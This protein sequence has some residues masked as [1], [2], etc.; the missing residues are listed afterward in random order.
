MGD[1]ELTG[2]KALV[3]GAATKR[4]MG[5]AIA[6]RLAEEGAD[7]AV[8]DRDPAPRSLFP[9]DE[10]WRGLDEIAEEIRQ[11]GRDA[12]TIVADV[13][14]F[15]E[16]ERAAKMVVDRFGGIDILVHCAAIRG[17]PNIDVVDGEV[18]EWRRIFEVN[19]L[20]S[21]IV[22]KCVGRYMIE[23]GGGKIVLFA[24][25]AAR[26]GVKG[27]AA[28]A[29]SKWGVIGLVQSLALEL[30]PYKINVNAVCP[31]MIITN[32]RD[33]YFE[34]QAR[35]M[36]TSPEEVRQKEYAELSKII[37]LGRMGT[38]EDIANM[39]SFLVS[40]KSNYITGQSINVCGGNHM[41]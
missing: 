21:F 35:R 6:L 14:N 29:A 22:S 26:M 10:G 32:L 17:R 31:G 5:H 12:L 16:I 18:E 15:P 38:V 37:P 27:S 23:R 33:E 1:R 9:G 4:G 2:K 34:E 30:A 25:L 8:L 3:T 36:G 28:Y 19:L 20:G 40:E 39:V 13:S 41:D 7:V 11:R 24:S